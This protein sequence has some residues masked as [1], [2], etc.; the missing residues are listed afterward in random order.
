MSTQTNPV[1]SERLP[2]APS[3]YDPNNPTPY[4][5]PEPPP[6]QAPPQLPAE[7]TQ[8][9]KA[10]AVARSGGGLATAAFGLDSILKGYMRGRE[11]AQ[12]KQAYKAQQLSNG[13]RYAYETAAANY[14]DLIRQGKSPDDPEVQKADAAQKAAYTALTQMQGNWI[15]NAAGIKQKKSKGSDSGSGDQP[16]PMQLITSN[17]PKQK[18]YGA[19]L[20]QQ[21]LLQQ[22]VTPANA[23]ARQYL[24]PEYQAQRKLY[25]SEQTLTQ[26]NVDDK[27]ALRNLEMTDT[28]KMTPEQKNEHEQKVQALRDRI[29]EATTGYS[30][31][32]KIIDKKTTSDNHQWVLWQEPS[33]KT[34]WEDQGEQRGLASTIAKPGSEQAFIESVAKEHGINVKDLSAQSQLDLRH[35][36]LQSAQMGKV[37]GQNYVYTDKETGNIVVVPLTK[38]TSATPAT[39]PNVSATG[40]ASTGATTTTPS[41]SHT[42]KPKVGVRD[43]PE[44]GSKDTASTAS[45]TPP[46]SPAGSRIIG[47]TLSQ[48]KAK[49]QA[50]TTDE[51]KKMKPLFGLLAAQED[52]M[53]EIAADPSKATPRQ[54]LS[55]VVASVRSMNPGSVRLPQKELELEIKAGSWGDRAKRWYDNASTGLLPDDQRKDLF[56]IVQRETTKAGESI[57]ADWQQNMSG[58]PLPNDIKRF[59]KSGSGSDTSGNAG[60]PTTETPEQKQLLDKY[61]PQPAVPK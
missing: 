28:S 41:A 42:A 58:Q 55:L 48:P 22:G 24:T 35:A 16:D 37:V 39:V 1:W 60:D 17:D 33:G 52:Y 32:E 31:K 56:G 15:K 36:W 2:K 6:I 13:L 54:D 8:Q 49:T 10:P 26:G 30:Q 43:L 44:P 9:P 18:M 50:A 20:L 59:A 25:Q 47:H 11:Q 12:Q 4:T 46:G 61:F 27:L 21:R 5:A 45:A 14:V 7:Q 40:S 19:W 57:A 23:A 53:K 3:T 34:R 29:S 51:Y 38:T